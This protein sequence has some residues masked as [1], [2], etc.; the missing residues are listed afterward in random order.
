MF[1]F[2]S[3]E[4]LVVNAP[5]REGSKGSLK[6]SAISP[7]QRGQAS[8]FKN[9][10]RGSAFRFPASFRSLILTLL[11]EAPET[12]TL[13][14]FALRISSDRPNVLYSF[15]TGSFE[16][17][18][19]RLSEGNSIKWSKTCFGRRVAREGEGG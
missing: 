15:L 7:R 10:F 8:H 2:V 19:G 18:N 16:L 17:S 13:L 3:P 4:F 1:S 6:I 14:Y 9:S 12:E 5:I 11:L